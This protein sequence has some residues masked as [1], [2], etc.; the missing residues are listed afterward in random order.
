[1]ALDSPLVSALIRRKKSRQ[2]TKSRSC[3]DER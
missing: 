2:V 1:M 3:F